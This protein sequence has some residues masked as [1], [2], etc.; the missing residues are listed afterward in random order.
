M[1]GEYCSRLMHVNQ[2]TMTNAHATVQ[3]QFDKINKA[4]VLSFQSTVVQVRQR[5]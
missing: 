5:L 4:L 1:C 3:I 2:L